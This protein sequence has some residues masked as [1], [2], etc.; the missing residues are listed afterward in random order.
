MFAAVLE[1]K[2]HNLLHGRWIEPH[3]EAIRATS[4][5]IVH[6]LLH[7]DG[8]TLTL[9]LLDPSAEDAAEEARWVAYVCERPCA[10]PTNQPPHQPTTPVIA[11]SARGH[12]GPRRF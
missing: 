12:L 11:V 5:R 4:W 8:G 9:L 1:E 3:P 6:N 2:F 10:P 7:M